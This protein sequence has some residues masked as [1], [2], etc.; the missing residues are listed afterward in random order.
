MINYC[1]N[2][3]C[4]R[5]YCLAHYSRNILGAESKYYVPVKN[6]CSNYVSVMHWRTHNVLRNARLWVKR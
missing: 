6:K 1:N 4:D 2:E 3:E 5:K